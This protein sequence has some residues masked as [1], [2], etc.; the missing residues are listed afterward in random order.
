MVNGRTSWGGHPPPPLTSQR[1]TEWAAPVPEDEGELSFDAGT[2]TD[3]EA[4]DEEGDH[5]FS[6]SKIHPRGGQD[7]TQRLSA[8]NP[9]A[10]GTDTRPTTR[11]SIGSSVADEWEAEQPRLPKPRRAGEETDVDISELS[12]TDFEEMPESSSK[13]RRG[14]PVAPAEEERTAA[15]V[16]A[17]EG[18]GMIVHLSGSSLVGM[19]MKSGS[20][21]RKNHNNLSRKRAQANSTARLF[22][23][24]QGLPMS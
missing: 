8:K 23:S 7:L 21:E 15:I 13:K 4:D 19:E 11:Y 1:S 22:F 6:S 9:G 10:D 17:E 20:C 14:P 5:T 2:G 24:S 12:E 18:G 16:V 3:L